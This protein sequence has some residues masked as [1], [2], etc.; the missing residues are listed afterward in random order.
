MIRIDAHQ[1]YWSLRR[2]DYAWLTPR[3]TGLYR[4]FEPEHLSQDLAQCGIRATVSVQAAPT[5]AESRFLFDLSVRH[6]SIAGIV[7]WVD[8]EADDVA[9]R[10][11]SLVRDG[12]GMLKGLRPMVQD[13]GDPGWLDRR[14][15]DAA[16]EAMILHDLAFDALVTPTHLGAIGRRLRRHPQL[17]AILDH[18]GKP[19]IG[20]ANL[21][22]WAAQ[23][24]ELARETRVFCKLSGLLTQAGR[25]ARIDEID[26]AAARV[27]ECFGVERLIWG[28]DWPVVTLRATYREWLQ[29]SLEL[30][31][32]HAPGGEDAIFG[33]NAVDFYRLEVAA[34]SA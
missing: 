5:E 17:R 12:R 32:R 30:V 22:A 23:I 19:D 25:G 8:F 28:S 16:F 1:H 3:E 34:E 6:P 13:I 31:R 4:D 9:E 14:G 24:G 15:L 7:G 33:A 10:I 27:F 11:N 21:E 18:A 29:M 2:G 26:A 20:G